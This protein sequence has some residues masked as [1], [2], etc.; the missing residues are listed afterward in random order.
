[1]NVGEVRCEKI[2]KD[3]E[4]LCVDLYCLNP[5]RDTASLLFYHTNYVIITPYN[6]VIKFGLFFTDAFMT[7]T[8]MPQFVD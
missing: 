6:Y 4:M 7:L 2:T 5:S 8:H 1:M 3:G